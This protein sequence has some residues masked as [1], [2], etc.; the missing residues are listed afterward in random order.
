MCSTGTDKLLSV[1]GNAVAVA[2]ESTHFRLTPTHPVCA[3]KWNTTEHDI[4][5]SLLLTHS[6]SVGS[7]RHHRRRSPMMLSHSDD[8]CVPLRTLRSEQFKL[9]LNFSCFRTHRK[10]NANP[11]VVH[12]YCTWQSLWWFIRSV[13][14][15][16]FARVLYLSSLDCVSSSIPPLH[17]HF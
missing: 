15:S 7:R 1:G 8:L 5:V 3:P 10:V 9:T 6:I 4:C 11:S 14:L 2:V 12:A 17:L 13:E 16:L